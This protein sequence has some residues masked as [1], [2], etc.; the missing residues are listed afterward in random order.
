MVDWIKLIVFSR[1]SQKVIDLHFFQIFAV[2]ALGL[3]GSALQE[4]SSH[5]IL[6]IK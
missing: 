6:F 2:V 1:A 5:D 4:G 3:F